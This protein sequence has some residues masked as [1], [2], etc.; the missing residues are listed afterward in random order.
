MRGAR[1]S[2]DDLAVRWETPRGREIKREVL[3]DIRNN[4]GRGLER[5]LK[6]F[7][8]TDEVPHKADLRCIT[9]ED[10]EMEDVTFSEVDLSWASFAK[11]NLQR[12][13]FQKCTLKRAN[14][15]QCNLSLAR[16]TDSDCSRVDF[17]AVSME[18]ANFR[19]SKL[20]GA[21][22]VDANMPRVSFEGAKCNKVNFHG[23][24][25]EQCNF[26]GADC[27]S[28]NFSDGALDD[29]ASRPDKMDGVRFGA[30]IEEFESAVGLKA[31]TSRSTRKFKGLD[32]LLKVSA[33]AEKKE[34][35]EA[36]KKAEKDR[37]RQMLSKSGSDDA[38]VASGQGGMVFGATLPIGTRA[39]RSAPYTLPAQ[40][41]TPPS[42]AA[43]EK[44][45]R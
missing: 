33:L 14:F 26:H 28:A 5:V 19:D 7:I 18:N 24:N 16:F 9:L 27:T 15:Q 13:H 29:L 21:I 10:Q 36:A 20:T 12:S 3:A 30:E 40:R 44:S 2:L 25:I 4:G 11:S 41:A 8:Y 23:A 45:D 34:A 43:C 35:A 17:T 42:I 6:D 22:C 38:D 37:E 1:A 32:M 31:L 39:P